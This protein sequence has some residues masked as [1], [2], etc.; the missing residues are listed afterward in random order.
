LQD[1]KKNLRLQI[2]QRLCNLENEEKEKLDS[3]I[4]KRLNHFLDARINMSNN[5]LLTV[6]IF[7]PLSDEVYWPDY[8]ITTLQLAF[9]EVDGHLMVFRQCGLEELVEV[10]LFGRKMRVPGQGKSIV[11]PDIIIVPAIAFDRTGNRLGRGG[12]FY[13]AYL[14]NFDGPKIGIC[15]ELQLVDELP[16]EEH[17]V[18]VDFVITEKMVSEISSIK[19]G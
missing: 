15:K 14:R 12:G 10:E 16:I 3:V 19:G 5:Q 6:G 17:D 11:K 1:A 2:K 18:K 7:Y 9:P 13:D 4:S 8:P